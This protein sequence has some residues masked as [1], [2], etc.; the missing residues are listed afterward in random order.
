MAKLMTGR[1]FTDEARTLGRMG[2]AGMDTKKIRGVMRNGF[3]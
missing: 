3:S 1:T 2:L